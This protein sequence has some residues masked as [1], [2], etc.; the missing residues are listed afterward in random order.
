[1]HRC[2]QIMILSILTCLFAFAAI[3]ADLTT[4]NDIMAVFDGVFTFNTTTKWSLAN[5]AIELGMQN[6]SREFFDDNGDGIITELCQ[7]NESKIIS[8]IYSPNIDFVEG[9]EN[10]TDDSSDQ[11]AVEFIIAVFMNKFN[12]IDNSYNEIREISVNYGVCSENSTS[13]SMTSTT[14]IETAPSVIEST[15]LLLETTFAVTDDDTDHGDDALT[16]TTKYGDEE[17]YDYTYEI[18][19]SIVTPDGVDLNTD[20]VLEY[21]LAALN[22]SSILVRYDIT[23]DEGMVMYEFEPMDEDEHDIEENEFGFFGIVAFSSDTIRERWGMDHDYIELEMAYWIAD[24]WGVDREDYGNLYLQMAF[25]GGDE[26][27]E[28]IVEDGE[29]DLDRLFIL[30]T[31]SSIS[32]CF[33]TAMVACCDKVLRHNELFQVGSLVLFVTYVLDF[34]SGK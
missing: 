19:F 1:M 14:G 15:T 3:F 9:F 13:T 6:I 23:A 8:F 25:Y 17:E 4:G 34:V 7:Y 10:I 29:A 33:C 2:D 12:V 5:K 31:L 28:E 24:R 21:V 26:E 22:A 11:T 32:I 27:E 16:T 20:E 18:E 30:F